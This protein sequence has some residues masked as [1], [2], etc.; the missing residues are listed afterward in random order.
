MESFRPLTL[1]GS[2][3]HLQVEATTGGRGQLRG[4]ARSSGAAHPARQASGAHAPCTTEG[5][6]V[7][8]PVR[9]ALR[10]LCPFCPRPRTRRPEEALLPLLS[11]CNPLPSQTGRAPRVC[12]PV[13]PFPALPLACGESWRCTPGA[14]GLPR[15]PQ[16]QSAAGRAPDQDRRASESPSSVRPGDALRG[17]LLFSPLRICDRPFL[18]SLP[19]L[20]LVPYLLPLARGG[21]Q[22]P[23]PDPRP[24]SRTQPRGHAP[25]T[26]C[27]AAGCR[28]RW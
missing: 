17:A 7:P 27:P 22:P 21:L 10:L 23:S 20:L 19:S 25:L 9:G 8:L 15:Q 13:K 14:E 5:G 3:T 4:L 12:T 28:C 26:H 24:R 16:R 1:S 6:W 11:F 18:R 2:P